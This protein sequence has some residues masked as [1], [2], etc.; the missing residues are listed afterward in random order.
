[1]NIDKWIKDQDHRSILAGNIK[2]A[3]D[4]KLR[5]IFLGGPKYRELHSYDFE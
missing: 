1:M 4:V 5:K 2:I 3:S